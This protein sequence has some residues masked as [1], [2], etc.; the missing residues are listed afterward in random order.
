MS[1]TQTATDLLAALD[2]ATE[3]AGALLGRPLVEN[4]TDPT[5]GE[6]AP[7][8]VVTDN[9][10]AMKSIATARW[11]AARPH[12]AHVRTRHRAPHTNGVV[13]RWFES[14]KY[15][16]LYRE[17]IPDG[18][19]LAQHVAAFTDEYNTIRSHEALDWQRPLDA[20]CPTRPSNPTRPR[21]SKELDTGH[22]VRNGPLRL[23]DRQTV[24]LIRCWL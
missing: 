13:E 10:P 16:R 14:L 17:D 4:C 22:P 7:L 21:L 5:T 3:A 23:H 6:I 18:I 19:D 1:A 9:G 24:F 8:V 11:F 2:A 20:T 15:E 12:L